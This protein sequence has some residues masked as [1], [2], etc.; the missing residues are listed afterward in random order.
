MFCKYWKELDG[1]G[2]MEYEFC[3]LNFQKCICCGE[4][5]QCTIKYDLE[6][7]EEIDKNS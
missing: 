5:E 1:E 7:A 2:G 3:R 6:K 4:T